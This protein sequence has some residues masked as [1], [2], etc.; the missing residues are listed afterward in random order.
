MKNK[1]KIKKFNSYKMKKKIQ[2]STSPFEYFLISFP[3]Y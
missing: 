2:K 3:T 1:M